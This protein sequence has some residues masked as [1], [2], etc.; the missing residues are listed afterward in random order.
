MLFE[1]GNT[2]SWAYRSIG[3]SEHNGGNSLWYIID[4]PSI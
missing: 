3:L 2:V 1:Q 4:E